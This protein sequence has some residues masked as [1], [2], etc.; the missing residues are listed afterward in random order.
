MLRTIAIVTALLALA[1][2]GCAAQAERPDPSQEG[3]PDELPQPERSMQAEEPE[4]PP[5]VEQPPGFTRDTQM[6]VAQF[7]KHT[8]DSDAGPFYQCASYKFIKLHGQ[9]EFKRYTDEF[10]RESEQTPD[11]QE[12]ESIQEHLIKSGYTCSLNEME[13]FER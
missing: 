9:I 6:N 3:V 4:P 13:Y 1:S 10:L 7:N 5:P 8:D 12:V 11:S 2:L